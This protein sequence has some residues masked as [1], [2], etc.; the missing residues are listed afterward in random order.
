LAAGAGPPAKTMAT[1]RIFVSERG[2]GASGGT[3]DIGISD[4]LN[5]IRRVQV[6][7]VRSMNV[8]STRPSTNAE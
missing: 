7:H 4:Y 2:G 6:T 3:E 8:V 1:R 5:K